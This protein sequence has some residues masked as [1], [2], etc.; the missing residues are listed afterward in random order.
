MLATSTF[1]VTCDLLPCLDVV[2][3][4]ILLQM[5][6]SPFFIYSL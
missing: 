5:E 1:V 6:N 4:S 3:N 2:L